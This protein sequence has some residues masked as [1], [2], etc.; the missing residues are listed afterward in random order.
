MGKFH[1]GCTWLTLSQV[2]LGDGRIVQANANTNSD[3]FQALKGSQNNLGIITSFDIIAFQQ[4]ELWG[5]TAI[6]NASTVPAQIEAFVDFT[7]NVE[8]DPY[9]SLIFDWIYIAA[10]N[11]TYLEN[12]YDYTGT[13]KNNKTEYPPA[14]QGFTPQSKV[15]PPVN[16]TLRIDHLSSLIAELNSPA[17]LR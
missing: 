13:Y 5:G 16:N 10:T 12:I 8:K 2:V 15:G 9:G 1:A 3:L 17:N 6:Y 7:N 4:G 14:F 11:D